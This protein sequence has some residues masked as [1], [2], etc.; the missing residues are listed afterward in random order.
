MAA[1]LHRPVGSLRLWRLGCASRPPYAHSRWSSTS[2]AFAPP[3]HPTPLSS[4]P[5][6]PCRPLPSTSLLHRRLLLSRTL[7]HTQSYSTTTTSIHDDPR[8]PPPPQPPPPKTSAASSGPPEVVRPNY[9][10]PFLVTLAATGFVISQVYKITVGAEYE[11]EEEEEEEELYEL[12]TVT[13]DYVPE[14]VAP[15]TIVERVLDSF[16]FVSRVVQ[17]SVLFSPLLLAMPLAYFSTTAGDFWWRYLRL[18]LETLGGAW[19][20]LGQWASTRPDLFSQEFID[21][22]TVFQRNSPSHSWNHTLTEL[23]VA[24]ENRP[25]SSIF[26]TFER[27][28]IASGAIAQVHRARLVTGENVAVKVL[29]PNMTSRIYVDLRVMRLVAHSVSMLPGTGFLDLR[30]ALSQF[31]ATMRSQAN[32]N[33]EGRNLLEFG[34]YFKDNKRI[35]FPKYYS[36]TPHVLVESYEE[37]TPLSKFLGE[38][39]ELSKSLAKMGLDAYLQMMLVDNFVHAD[40]HPGS[41]L[42]FRSRCLP[43]SVATTTTTTTTTSPPVCCLLPL[44]LPLSTRE[45]RSETPR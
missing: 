17:I 8:L 26:A 4:S 25:L 19:I 38:R 20:K 16:Y 7:Q 3:S 27:K 28:P 22:L 12:P 41:S 44:P 31:S 43:S 11:V 9:L 34:K 45:Y 21:H 2:A 23:K 33:S 40:L 13:E 35:V 14:P 32:L 29:H 24:F 15:R 5:L 6:F 37:A 42:N 1:F 36:S 10:V 18:S 39:S 30:D